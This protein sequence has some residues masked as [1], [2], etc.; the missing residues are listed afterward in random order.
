MHVYADSDGESHFGEIEIE[1]TDSDFAPPAASLGV[2]EFQPS[3]STGFI[4]GKVGWL[5]EWHPVPRRQYTTVLSGQVEVTTSDQEPRNFGPGD[6]A[7]FED[8]TGKGH[9]SRTVGDLPCL[10]HVTQIGD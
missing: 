6:I 5:G 7:L 2:S 10:V 3:D 1:F 4:R 8:T 9:R